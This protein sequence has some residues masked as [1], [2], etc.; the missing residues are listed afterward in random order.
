MAWHAGTG[1][2]PRLS[3]ADSGYGGGTDPGYGAGY[4]G[5]T[6]PGYRSGSPFDPGYGYTGGPWEDRPAAHQPPPPAT[7]HS[8]AWQAPAAEPP[9]SYGPVPYTGPPPPPRPGGPGDWDNVPP[10]RQVLWWTL[11]FFVVPVLLYLLWA[12]TRSGALPPGCVEP[13]GSDCRSPRAEAFAALGRGAPGLVGAVL[14]GVAAAALLRG[15]ATAW[16]PAAIGLGGAVIGAGVAT[17]LT[18]VLT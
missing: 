8:G 7:G 12:A 3:A 2:T 11:A 18:T 16:R 15:Y 4:G 13:V 6:D 10:L 5:G 17:M 9:P 1:E 14:L